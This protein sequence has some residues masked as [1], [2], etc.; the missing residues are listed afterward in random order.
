MQ[1]HQCTVQ[2]IDSLAKRDVP[3]VDVLS[4]FETTSCLIRKHPPTLDQRTNRSD[5][6]RDFSIAWLR[7]VLGR[8]KQKKLVRAGIRRSQF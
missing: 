4:L 5:S 3:T 2:Y 8:K 7:I 1:S 6:L